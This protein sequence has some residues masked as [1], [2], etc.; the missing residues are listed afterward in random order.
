MDRRDKLAAALG[1]PLGC[2]WPEG[3][4]DVHPGRLVLWVGDQDMASTRQP[5]WPL[6]KAGAVDLFKPFPFGTDPR[7]RT[8][9]ME[10][11]YTNL[12][13]G[14]IPGYGKTFALRLPLLAA[15]LDPRA[16]LWVFELKG[17][18][19][20]APLETVSAR[21]ASGP[22][23]DTIEAALIALRELR[24]ECLR[25]AEVIRNL[26]RSVPGEQGHAG[27]GLA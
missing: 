18:G 16:E 24:K 12:L 4:P 11:M 8:V 7:G 17:S 10:L 20:L 22:D 21:Y 9:P 25:R 1:R 2:V 27:A 13:I 5:A 26:P 3:N 23:D 14:S 19:D 6:L 15:A